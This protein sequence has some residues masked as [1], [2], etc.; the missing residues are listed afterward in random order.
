M[1][2]FLFYLFFQTFFQRLGQVDF[3]DI[4]QAQCHTDEFREHRILDFVF[5]VGSSSSKRYWTPPTPTVDYFE[6]FYALS[7]VPTMFL[8]KD[9]NV[10]ELV[11]FGMCL[12]REG[13][14]IDHECH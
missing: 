2:F 1:F 11:F 13:I 10:I 12:S 5:Y 7:K 3:I 6:P 8:M 14:V 4:F 9:Y